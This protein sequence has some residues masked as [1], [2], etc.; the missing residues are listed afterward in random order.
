MSAEWIAAVWLLGLCLLGTIYFAWLLNQSDYSTWESCLYLPTYV[1]GRLLWR[2]HFTNQP[3]A[4]IERGAVM[5]ANHRSSVDP[6]FVQL[7]AR[8]R[9]HWM[10]A[11]EYCQHAVFGPLLRALQVIPTNRSG[12]DT[13]STKAALRITQAGRLVGM[14]PE[15]KINKTSQA[16]LPLRAGAALVAIRSQVPLIP[17]WIE[18]SPMGDAV[19]SPVLMPARVSITFGKPIYPVTAGVATTEEK[20][21]ENKAGSVSQALDQPT[22]ATSPAALQPAKDDGNHEKIQRRGSAELAHCDALIVQWGDEILALAGRAGA[23]VQ[24]ASQRKLRN[25]SHE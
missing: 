18:G 11:Q 2:V 15:G 21:E 9:V 23:T 6:F 4:E 7:A 8:R 17:L 12:M 16:L 22:N 10:V 14:F 5:A 20:T 13:A 25:R 24:L 19:W 3:P 1:L